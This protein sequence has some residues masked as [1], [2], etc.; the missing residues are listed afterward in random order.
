[1]NDELK[2]ISFS[3]KIIEVQL[4]LIIGAIIAY[5]LK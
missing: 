2:N 1:M 3:L 4:S 5:C